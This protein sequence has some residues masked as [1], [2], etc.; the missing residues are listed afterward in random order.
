MNLTY[1]R[2]L[3]DS[4]RWLFVGVGIRLKCLASIDLNAY[5][6]MTKGRQPQRLSRTLGTSGI[7]A[8]DELVFSA[9]GAGGTM[10]AEGPVTCLYWNQPLLHL[11]NRERV[12]LVSIDPK[13][14]LQNQTTP[15]YAPLVSI[16]LKAA[17]HAKADNTPSEPI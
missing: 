10:G 13:A 16:D 8:E 6:H 7:N 11:L 9:G 5:R 4:V 15:M 3:R 14:W 1:C 12:L 2:L 17:Y